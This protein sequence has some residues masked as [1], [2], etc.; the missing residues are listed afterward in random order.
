MNMVLEE[1]LVTDAQTVW[2]VPGKDRLRLIDGTTIRPTTDYFGEIPDPPTPAY[3]QVLYGYPRWW[4]DRNHIAYIPM[5]SSVNS[6]YGTSPIEFMIQVI[7]SAI[8]KDASLVANYTEGNIPAAFAGLPSTWTPE[9]IQQFTEWYNT[10]LAGDVGRRFKLVFLPHDGTGMPISKFDATDINTVS[11]DEWLMTV[12]CWAY[13]NDK[14]EFGLIGGGKSGLGGKGAAEGGEN[15]QVRGMIK[16]YTRFLSQFINFI[17]RTYLNAPYAKSH[18]VGMEPPED[19]LKT[20]QVHQIYMTAGVYGK[21]YVANQLGIPDKYRPVEP[22][23]PPTPEGFV[24]NAAAISTPA[25]ALKYQSHAIVGDLQKWDEKATRFA[26]KGWKQQDFTDTIIPDGLRK[27]IFSAVCSASGPEAVHNVFFAAMKNAKSEME[28]ILEKAA[29][30]QVPAP[31]G[32]PAVDPLE[33]VKDAAAKELEQ[34]M[35]EYLD[36]LMHRIT[37]H[38]AAGTAK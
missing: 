12:A 23:T 8:K 28:A 21:D 20:A 14:T 38:E 30:P 7:V 36:G 11:L 33:H 31:S 37:A 29:K 6:P 35:A 16:V 13:G 34:A 2:P 32:Q 1:V 24:A 10:I 3:I 19:E 25:E 4:S 26:K 5:R 22:P 9:Q 18:W 27:A 17:N 15:A